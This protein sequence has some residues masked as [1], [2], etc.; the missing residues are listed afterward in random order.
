MSPSTAA[1]IPSPRRRHP[2]AATWKSAPRNPSSRIHILRTSPRPSPTSARSSKLFQAHSPPAPTVSAWARA[3]PTSAASPTATTT[4]TSTAFPSLTPTHLLTT[5]GHSFPR[6]GLAAWTLIAAPAPPP[7]SDPPPSAAPSI[8][9][10]SRLAMSS[11]CAER[12]LR[13]L[14]HQAL[15]RRLQLRPFWNPR[16]VQE[17]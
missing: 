10:P 14:E 15:R 3:K 9:S 12:L 17:V 6:N 16:Q 5:P 7:P 2:A 4:S 13:H 8:C 11:T 1:S